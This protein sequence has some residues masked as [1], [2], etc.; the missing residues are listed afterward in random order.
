MDYYGRKSGRYRPITPEILAKYDVIISIGKTVQYALGMG[1]PVYT[2]DRLGGS[3]YITLENIDKEEYH[4]F[5]GKSFC[6]KI[7][8]AEIAKEI[9]DGFSKA[10]KQAQSLKK[11]A[12]DRY[13]LSKNIDR[14]IEILNKS[15]DVKIDECPKNKFYIRQCMFVVEQYQKIIKYK[16]YK[17]IIIRLVLLI[18]LFLVL[19]GMF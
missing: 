13:L 3:G 4:N 17:E 8:S 6:R 14:V 11:I 9:L 12:I 7:S 15:P 19:V 16:R 1:I 10:V 2:Y 18:V 5:S